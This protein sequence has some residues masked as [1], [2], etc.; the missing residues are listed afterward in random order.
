MIL[1]GH[2]LLVV[3]MKISSLLL[4]GVHATNTVLSFEQTKESGFSTMRP[5]FGLCEKVTSPKEILTP[6]H[7]LISNQGKSIES[8]YG[9]ILPL[10]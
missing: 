3:I 4:E 6:P 5:K 7:Q 10:R 8:K 1:C 2:Y 9:K